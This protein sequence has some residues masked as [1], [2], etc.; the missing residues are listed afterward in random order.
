MSWRFATFT[1]CMW[2][3]DDTGSSNTIADL[4][5]L[6]ASSARN[7]ARARHRSIVTDRTSAYIGAGSRLEERSLKLMVAPVAPRSGSAWFDAHSKAI[8]GQSR[9]RPVASSSTL[10]ARLGPSR[11]GM[12]GFMTTVKL[13]ALLDHVS[14]D[15]LRTAF[16]ALKKRTAAGIDQVTWDRYA[17]NLEENRQ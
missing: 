6:A 7:A 16:F 1:R 5:S 12:E 14:V 3:S 17:K 13:M 8:R 4:L 11:T 9:S 2:S 15:C 10:D